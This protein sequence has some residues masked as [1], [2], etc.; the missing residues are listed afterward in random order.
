MTKYATSRK[1]YLYRFV[2]GLEGEI[3]EQR[4]LSVVMVNDTNGLLCEYTLE[5]NNMWGHLHISFLVW[6]IY[7][8][9]FLAIMIDHGAE[10]DLIK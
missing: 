5:W 3:Q 9:Y 7:Y 2:S 6:R 10:I 4:L 8:N 1:I